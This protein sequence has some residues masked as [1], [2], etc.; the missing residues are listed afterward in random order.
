MIDIEY[1]KY[2]NEQPLN[3]LKKIA[4]RINKLHFP[5]EFKAVVKRIAELE[6]DNFDRDFY[7]DPKLKDALHLEITDYNSGEKRLKKSNLILNAFLITF[8]FILSINVFNLFINGNI[9]AIIP[10]VTYITLITLNINRSR[11]FGKAC[12]IWAVI[13]VIVV[14]FIR[15]KYFLELENPFFIN[16]LNSLAG[17][18]QIIQPS[19][20]LFAAG[21]LIFYY[22]NHISNS[23]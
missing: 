5:N 11:F 6:G 8:S 16:L 1:Q 23:N 13:V 2:I 18:N 19:V 12:K 4:M 15:F 7:F 9:L 22:A 17:S 3:E 10:V 21:I 20:I 14:L